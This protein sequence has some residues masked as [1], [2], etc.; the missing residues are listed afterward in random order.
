MQQELRWKRLLAVT[1]RAD[2]RWEHEWGLEVTTRFTGQGSGVR[3][4]GLE[5]V[6]YYYILYLMYYILLLYVLYIIITLYVVY[7]YY[8]FWRQIVPTDHGRVQG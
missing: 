5:F 3:G 6:Y 1:P 2:L 8:M 4:Q 7:Y